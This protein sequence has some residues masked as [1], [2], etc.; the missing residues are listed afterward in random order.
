MSQT[1]IDGLRETAPAENRWTSRRVLWAHAGMLAVVLFGILAVVNN[2][3]VGFADEGIYSAQVDNLSRGSWSAPLPVPDIDPTG[4]WNAMVGS[5]TVEGG[6]YI[7]YARHALYPLIL[8]PFFA[9]GGFAGMLVSST[10]SV[11]GA[12]VAAAFLARRIDPRLG[13]PTLWIMGIGSPLVFDTAFLVG[14]ALAAALTGLLMLLLFWVVDDRCHRWLLLALPIAAVLAMVRSEGLVAVAGIGGAFG[15]TALRFPNIRSTNLRQG[16]IATAVI[17]TGI[18]AYM[19]DASIADAIVGIDGSGTAV[20]DRDRGA[21]SAAWVTLLRPWSGPATNMRVTTIL[22]P[23][24]VGLA[25][26]AFRSMPKRPLLAIGLVC[27]AGAALV[28]H[29][30][31]EPRL[32]SGLVPA[33]P[34]LLFGLLMLTVADLRRPAVTRL[35]LASL[36]VVSAVLPTIYKVGGATEWG[37]RFFR[38]L[39]PLAV[40]LVALGLQRA[41][42]RLSRPEA[43]VALGAL[44]VATLALSTSALRINADLRQAAR[45]LVETTMAVH[46]E[47]AHEDAVIV[48]ASFVP[49]GS[50]RAFWREVGEG[51]PILTSH[52]IGGLR[53]LVSVTSS[54]GRPEMTV[55]TDVPADFL[56][57]I[58]S[59][60]LDEANWQI[61]TRTSAPPTEFAVYQLGPT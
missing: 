52:G 3:F 13:I 18:I 61:R 45:S 22:A 24:C 37:G 11:L 36:L 57:T 27:V 29:Q 1:S 5:T 46:D 10:L 26:I 51:A 7:P 21:W 20:L 44:A 58:I 6:R 16:V 8:L 38:V 30:F 32:I 53:E 12:S 19:A 49:S 35:C 50:P 39:L 60:E 34:L 47:E 55:V 15:L 17:A 59:S 28:V 54:S 48:V 2:G 23:V 33:F 42:A 41:A 9:L 56:A 43:A 25:A 31:G 4:E 40:P 14:H